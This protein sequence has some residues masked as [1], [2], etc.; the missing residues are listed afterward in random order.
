MSTLKHFT[1]NARVR[2]KPRDGWESSGRDIPTF[3][4]SA[5]SGSHAARLV[6]RVLLTSNPDLEY[7]E[8]SAYGYQNN[9]YGTVDTNTY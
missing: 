1:I 9:D 5:N 3:Q 2:S 8:V 6:Y 4:V 7:I